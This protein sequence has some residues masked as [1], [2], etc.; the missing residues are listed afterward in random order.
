M[1]SLLRHLSPDKA[2]VLRQLIEET[3]GVAGGDRGLLSKGITFKYLPYTFE[4]RQLSRLDEEER[5]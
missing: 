1:E 5:A 2:S 4:T 3:G